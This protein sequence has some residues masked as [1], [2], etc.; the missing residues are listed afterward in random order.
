MKIAYVLTTFPSPT[1]T[2]AAREMAALQ[3]LGWE[4]TVLAARAE[5]APAAGAAAFKATYKPSALSWQ[6]L[7]ALAY[8]CRHYPLAFVRLAVLAAR[9]LAQCPR[10]C[11]TLLA[12]IHTVCHFARCLDRDG[13]G[14][15]HAFFLS[16]PAC[17]GLAV[18]KATR[19]RFS[20][21]AHARDIFVEQG[22][23]AIKVRA[24][25]FVAICTAQGLERLKQLLPAPEH[26][27]LHLVRHGID[28]SLWQRAQTAAPPGKQE[29]TRE[30]R[31]LFVG[32][33]VP[34]KGLEFL[35]R[36]FAAVRRQRPACMLTIIG[37][38]PQCNAIS[39]L[40]GSLGLSPCVEMLGWR[41]SATVA[42]YMRRSALLAAPSMIDAQG[43]RDG[44]PN[45]ILEAFASGAVVVASRLDGVAEA[46]KDGQTG[47]LVDPGDAEQLAGAILRLL[48]DP[49]TRRRLGQGAREFV[50]AEFEARKNV[51]QLAALFGQAAAGS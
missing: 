10:E 41:D 24:A 3:A 15:V 42:D 25:S 17:I 9:M 46:V 18:A 45:V 4:V 38:G 5:V 44:V 14:L 32:R 1:E 22:A 48:A 47:C 16:W 20:L 13:V 36:A 23:A 49:S 8:L 7:S 6:S 39:E 12:N 34:K 11:L 19:R 43:D 28:A 51:A 50:A 29:A 40:I 33:L 27:K 21:S 35:V 37:D 30:D 31:V 26:S 2:F